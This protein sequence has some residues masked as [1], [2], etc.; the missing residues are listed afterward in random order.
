LAALSIVPGIAYS[1]EPYEYETY[2]NQDPV[3]KA[4]NGGVTV[5]FSTE[6]GDITFRSITGYRESKVDNED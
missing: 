2:L 1:T 5:D 3:T 4:E 6:L